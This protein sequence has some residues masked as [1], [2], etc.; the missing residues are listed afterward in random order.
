VNACVEVF[1]HAQISSSSAT[2]TCSS[3]S[4]GGNCW[5]EETG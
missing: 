2:R 5:M 1:C 4:Q 3:T